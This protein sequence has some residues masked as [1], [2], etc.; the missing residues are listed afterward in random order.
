MVAVGDRKQKRRFGRPPC[1]GILVAWR[2]ND[3]GLRRY[4]GRLDR[5]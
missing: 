2:G 4:V 5:D 1:N 3:G